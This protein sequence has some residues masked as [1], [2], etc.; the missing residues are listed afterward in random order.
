MALKPIKT[1]QN[2]SKPIKTIFSGLNLRLWLLVFCI[3][4]KITF[5]KCVKIVYISWM[6]LV[7][8]NQILD[9]ELLKNKINKINKKESTTTSK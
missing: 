7:V 4:F 5:I 9:I 1:N 6:E 8:M 2:Q 3:A